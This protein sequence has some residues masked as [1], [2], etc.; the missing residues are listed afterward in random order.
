MLRRLRQLVKARDD[1]AFESTLSGEIGEV[2]WTPSP[3]RLRKALATAAR[4]AR[5]LADAFG[6]KVPTAPSRKRDR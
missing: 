5:R 3:Q 4:D 6:V 1:F 2:P